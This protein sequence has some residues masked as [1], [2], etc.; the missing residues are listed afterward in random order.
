MSFYYD[1]DAVTFS[2][3]VWASAEPDKLELRLHVTRVATPTSKL[4]GRAEEATL[5]RR[6]HCGRPDWN[7]LFAMWR[8][9]YDGSDSLTVNSLVA[10]NNKSNLRNGLMP[11]PISTSFHQS[12]NVTFL[13]LLNLIL[14]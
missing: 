5:L 9:L 8:D 2:I 14:D 4:T 1:I 3:Q 7:Q 13:C 12:L 10:M 11:V 6:V